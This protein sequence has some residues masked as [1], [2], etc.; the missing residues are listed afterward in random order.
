M[1]YQDFPEEINKLNADLT[2][3]STE[4]YWVCFP[5]NIERVKK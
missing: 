3:K 1:Y 4:G 5:A 2:A